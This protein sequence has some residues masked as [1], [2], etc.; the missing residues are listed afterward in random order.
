MENTQIVFLLTSYLS[1]ACFDAIGEQI[2][3]SN[4]VELRHAVDKANISNYPTE[5]LLADGIYSNMST[6]Q[7][8]RDNVKISSLSSDPSRV[9]V[10]GGGMKKSDQ[11]RVIFDINASNITISAITLKDVSH[12][13]IQVRAENNADNFTLR[14][15]V[16]QDAYQQLLKVSGKANG[17]YSDFGTIKNNLF[18]YSAG[19]GPNYYI[20]GIDAHRSRFWKVT[21]N[22]FYNIASPRDRV[23]EH[24]IH[25]WNGSSDNEVTHNLIVNSDRGIGFGLL[26]QQSPTYGGVIAFNHII[27][28]NPT[29]PFA[30]A[31]ITLESS[32]STIVLD[33]NIYMTSD[34]P[35]AIEYRFPETK[36]VLIENN[37]TN[38]AIK[39]RNG[40]RAT[41]KNNTSQSVI[42]NFFTS[43]Y[44]NLKIMKKRLF[45]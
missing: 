16:L 30:D 11:T 39:A 44:Y 23:A 19:I 21:N 14:N 37:I 36:N 31:A 22:R 42:R 10:S 12:H 13:L 33:N 20:G 35:N 5:I 27:H 26:D 38:K 18:E 29:H 2:I 32:P 25:F 6:M 7:I 15:C 8:N 41:L 28:T 24:A 34:Y 40:A 4:G 9:V 17:E 45:D 43:F 3:V 1:I